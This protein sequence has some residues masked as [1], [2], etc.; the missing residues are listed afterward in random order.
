[1]VDDL[2]TNNE[3]KGSNLIPVNSNFR[4]VNSNVH[5]FRQF[6]ATKLMTFA[7]IHVSGMTNTPQLI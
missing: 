2:L 1:M 4:A 7:L 3:V 5:A 6:Q